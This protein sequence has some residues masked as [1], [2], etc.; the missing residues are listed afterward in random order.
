MKLL[1]QTQQN[2]VGSE[3]L[4][5]IAIVRPILI[6]LLTGIKQEVLGELGGLDAMKLFMLPRAYRDGCGDVGFC[7]EWAVHDAIRRNDPMVME[8]LT[9][10]AKLCKLPGADFD[11]ILFGVEKSGKTRIIDTANDVLTDDSRILTGAQAQPPKLKG[12]MNQLAAAFHRPETRS[13]LPSSI[14]GLWK[15]DLFFGST[16]ADRWLGTTLKINAK[17]LE[18]AR[19]LRVGIVPSTQGASDRIF[20]DQAKN[21]IVCPV[22]YD[23]SFM[24]L[25]YTGWRIVQ[26]FIAADAKVPKPVSLPSPADRQV[27]RELEMRR[28][29]P[30]VDVIAA[31]EAQAQTDLLAAEE[32]VVGSDVAKEGEPLLNDLVVSP[33]AAYKS[34]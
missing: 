31:L 21:L 30:I 8:R 25:F 6:A 9:D 22:P 13:A 14:N 20:K 15:A 4:A 18:G 17:H 11:S 32:K 33:V 23:G 5:R 24:E 3:V 16:D 10:A 27:A 12:Y 2:P 29:F 7:F 26:Q 19:G 28:D 34:A 1:I